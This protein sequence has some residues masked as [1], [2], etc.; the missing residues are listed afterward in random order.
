[1]INTK[2]D[3]CQFAPYKIKNRH[4]LICL[5]LLFYVAPMLAQ[6][7]IATDFPNKSAMLDLSTQG[8]GFLIPRLTTIQRNQIVSPAR[9]LIIYNTSNNVLEVYSGPIETPSWVGV[10]G[11]KGGIGYTGATGPTRTLLT[12]DTSMLST[13]SGV[14][15]SVDGGNNNAADGAQSSVLGGNYNL[16]GGVNSI[17]I[18]GFQNKA[19]GASSIIIGGHNNQSDGIESCVIGGNNNFATGI[20]SAVTGGNHNLSEVSRTAIIGG[21]YNKAIY[22][23][24]VVSGGNNNLASG[25]KSVVL[26]GQNNISSGINATVVG[27]F[28]NVSIG[29]N[30]SVIGGN[31]NLSQGH[32]SVVLAGNFNKA[33]GVD[34]LIASGSNNTATGDESTVSSGVNNTASSYGEWVGGLFP[35]YYV[36]LSTTGFEGDDRLLNIG[37]G[38]NYENRSDAFTITKNGLAVLPSVTNTLI[39]EGSNKSI[40]TKE[41]I[42]E[43]VLQFKTTAIASAN[44]SGV[45]GQIRLTTDFIYICVAPNTWVRKANSTTPW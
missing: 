4:L 16:A 8:K 30:S 32:N 45:I 37:S 9:G 39:D 23:D 42:N 41:Y 21:N 18:G 17:V 7:G 5:F 3:L 38:S 6:V 44:E 13:A 12:I 26:G 27:G 34:S 28:M 33:I 1:M 19:I 36:P 11:A 20:N 24:A 40:I 25:S 29:T 43:N 14:N 10:T 15:S 2:I 31:N 35:T 22:E